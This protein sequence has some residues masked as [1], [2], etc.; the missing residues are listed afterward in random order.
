MEVVLVKFAPV[1]V[2]PERSAPVS[3]ADDKDAPARFAWL[4]F[5]FVSVTE[6][7]VAFVRLA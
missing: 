6:E 5:A 7:R 3:V 1:T 2:A 4:K